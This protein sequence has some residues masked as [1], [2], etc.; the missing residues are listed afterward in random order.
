MAKP[1]TQLSDTAF[2]SAYYRHQ[3]SLRSHPLFVDRD[4]GA[5]AAQK[6]R[7]ISAYLGA[8]PA[9]FLWVNAV[10]THCVDALLLDTLRDTPTATV[11]NIGCGFDTRP[12]RLTLPSRLRWLELDMPSVIEHK[13]GVLQGRTA[14]CQVDRI[15]IDLRNRADRRA[16]LAGLGG[17]AGPVLVLAEACLPFISAE[18]NDALAEDLAGCRPVSHWLMDLYAPL[19]MRFVSGAVQ[20][21][22]KEGDGDLKFAPRDGSAFFAA[23]GWSEQRSVSVVATAR[24]LGRVPAPSAMFLPLLD[25]V[26]PLRRS[27]EGMYRVVVLNRTQ[28]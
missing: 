1:L 15:G 2:L 14:S 11:V 7:D 19:S 26:P 28:R 9:T 23:R 3:E 13:R 8:D 12:Y 24:A 21:R 25:L 22:L 16:V 6:G 5:L 27:L 4:A 18:D 10:R 17:D 20:R